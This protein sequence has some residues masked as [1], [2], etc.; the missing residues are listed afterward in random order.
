[1]KLG[2]KVK[3][4]DINK[5]KNDELLEKSALEIIKASKFCGEVTKIVD[6]IFMVGFKNEKGWVTQGYKEKEIEVV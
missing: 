3:V 1:M 4:K 5:V 2:S 6:D